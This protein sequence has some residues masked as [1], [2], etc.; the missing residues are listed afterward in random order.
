MP[1]LGKQCH[2]FSYFVLYCEFLLKI[3]KK[4]AYSWLNPPGLGNSHEFAAGKLDLPRPKRHVERVKM[5]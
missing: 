5:L 4:M 1:N 3:G 2:K